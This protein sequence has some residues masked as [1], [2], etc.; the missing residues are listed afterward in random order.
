MLLSIGKRGRYCVHGALPGLVTLAAYGKPRAP[1]SQRSVGSG[2]AM[3]R[4]LRM[5]VTRSQPKRSRASRSMAPAYTPRST[6]E[7]GASWYEK[8]S[9]YTAA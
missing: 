2:S 6:S 8:L 3:K 4:S 7:A 1:H 9:S 5:T